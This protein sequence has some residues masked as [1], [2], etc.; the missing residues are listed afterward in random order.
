MLDANLILD[1]CSSGRT[2]FVFSVGRLFSSDRTLSFLFAIITFPFPPR[3]RRK[4]SFMFITLSFQ[5]GGRRVWA[6]HRAVWSF[7][8][9]RTRW[10][11]AHGAHRR[12][13]KGTPS[14]SSGSW[15]GRMGGEQGAGFGNE[16]GVAQAY[17]RR[18]G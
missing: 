17:H 18:V 9:S 11:S 15:A 13:A 7:T 14:V 12:E 16:E 10:R 3:Q 6:E 1:Q 5:K 4:D 2:A 8:L